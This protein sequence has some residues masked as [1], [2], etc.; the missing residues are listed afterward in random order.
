M[1]RSGQK[2]VKKS[3]QES[4]KQTFSQEFESAASGSGSTKTQKQIS[5]QESTASSSG[6]TKTQK[7]T[8]IPEASEDNGPFR[9]V[10]LSSLY[11]QQSKMVP[12][13][14]NVT[15]HRELMPIT[16]T[17]KPYRSNVL[18]ELTLITRTTEPYR[19]N[20]HRELMPITR[21]IEPY[22]SN[23]RIAKPYR[24]NVR[25]TEPYR[26]ELTPIIREPYSSNWTRDVNELKYDEKFTSESNDEILQQ[27]ISRLIEA[28]KP[29]VRLLYKQRS[30]L[31]KDNHRLHR[32]NRLNEESAASGSSFTKTQK[33]TLIPE[34]S[35]DN[36]PFRLVV[37]SSL[38]SQQSR[39]VPPIRNVTVH[40][41]LTP[42]TRI[43]EPYRSNV[44]R[45]LTL[46]TRTTEPYRSNVRIAG[47]YRSN[48]RTARPYRSNV[49]TAEPYR[50]EL[51]PFWSTLTFF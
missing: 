47:P 31:D 33:Q 48:V 24:S 27:V 49:R 30:T 35:E 12:P 28:M 6:S 26:R 7:Q 19:S 37:P 1:K 34:A 20:I 5:K 40:R 44:H 36:G 21:I 16:R 51:T 29:R 18:R 13:I 43:A 14:R 32:N 4:H 22:R 15:I 38:Y 8:L 41:E 23:V 42:I 25:T 9:L 17:A 2:S 46:I 10:V 45:E 39:M 3:R 50:R 11:S